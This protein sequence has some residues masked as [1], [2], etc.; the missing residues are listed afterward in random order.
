MPAVEDAGR[1][2]VRTAEAKDFE[3]D[4]V[5][6]WEEGAVFALEEVDLGFAFD[7]VDLGCLAFEVVLGLIFEVECLE[8]VVGFGD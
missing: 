1:S 2:A 3:A 4:D 5:V 7:E 8:V 6:G